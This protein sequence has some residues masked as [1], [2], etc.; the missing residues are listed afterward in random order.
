MLQ[1][2]NLKK[3]FTH[4]GK[5]LA[6]LSDV[7]LAVRPGEIFGIV[8]KSGAGKSTLLKCFNLLEKPDSGI[9]MFDGVDLTKANPLILR[10]MR[11]KM[12]VIFQGFNLLSAKTVFANVALPLVLQG[13]HSKSEIK[14][15]VEELLELV[16]LKDYAKKYP[17]SLSGGQK[18]RV[19][20]A[21]ALSTN[22]S[23]LL[24]DE[25]T[26]ALDPQTT[27]SILNLLLDINERMGLTIVLITHE[28]DV[29]RKI[30]DRVAVIDHGKIIESGQAI[31]IVL[32]PKHELTR[33]LL[34]EEEVDKY[35]EQVSDFYQF[36]KSECS[37]LLILSYGKKVFEPILSDITND[38][39]VKFNILRGEIGRI[40]RT[41]FGQLLLEASG[42]PH[43]LA[44]AFTLLDKLNLDYEIIY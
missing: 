28:I 33:K 43:Q 5:D 21:R 19:G 13:N 44:K 42:E 35:L 17:A 7:S 34:L 24:S 14:N 37:N 22:P 27:N 36:T 23:L 31:D 32:H 39:G 12:G 3:T 20:I 30:C 16:G 8:G 15:K 9:V 1:V 11:Q 26:S 40:K 6:V 10:K 29:V 25:A 38:S 41:P 4:K 2:K 18:Q